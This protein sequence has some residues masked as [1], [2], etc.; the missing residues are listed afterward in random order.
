MKSVAVRNVMIG[1]GSPK[2]C[3]P[4]IGITK[5]DILEEIKNAMILDVDLIEWRVDWYE[6]CFDS[7]KV[8]EILKAMRKYIEQIPIIFTFRTAK[9]GGA[10]EITIENYETLLSDVIKSQQ[11]DVID[12]ELFT[13]EDTVLSLIEKAKQCSVK[14]ILSSHDFEKTP[15]KEEIIAR[16]CYMQKLGGDITKIAL[17]PRSKKDVLTLLCATEEMQSRYADRPYVTMSMGGIGSISRMVGEV[18]GVSITFGI[19]EYSSAPGQIEAQKLKQVLEI[20]H[21][22]MM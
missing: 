18:F 10:K 20:I 22:S 2:I 12:I 13:G 15:E 19:G 6:N 1:E 21:D 5:N 17:M 9:E 4:I 14:T 8:I 7:K 11:A 3:I 16:L